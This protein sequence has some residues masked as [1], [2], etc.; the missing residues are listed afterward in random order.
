MSACG[1]I[2]PSARTAI[3]VR[4]ATRERCFPDPETPRSGSSAL[5]RRSS[6]PV[7][8]VF[9]VLDLRPPRLLRPGATKKFPFAAGAAAAVAAETGSR[10]NPLAITRRKYLDLHHRSLRAASSRIADAFVYVSGLTEV[11]LD[12]VISAHRGKRCIPAPASRKIESSRVHSAVLFIF[13]AVSPKRIQKRDN[14]VTSS[15]GFFY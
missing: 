12:S 13:T 14:L 1:G 11:M 9:F 15:R 8:Y 6:F 7:V 4:C 5:P 2:I 3:A 10:G